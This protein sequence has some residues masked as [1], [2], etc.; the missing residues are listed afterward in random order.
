MTEQTQHYDDM[1]AGLLEEV[2]GEGYMSPGGP[3]EVARVLAGLDL[4]GLRVLD[5]GC[6]TGAI[7]LSLVQDHGAAYAVGIDVE[8]HVCDEARTRAANAGASDKVE[9]VLVDPGPLPFDEGH[10]DLVFSKDSIIHIADKEALAADIFRVLRPGGVFAASD[11]LTNHDGEMSPAMKRYVDLEGL[12]FAMASPERYAAAMTAAGFKDI[13]TNSR[14]AW[15]LSQAGDELAFLSGS[16]RPRLDS[17][18][19][20]QLVSDNIEVW[21]AMIAVLETGELAPHHLRG[22]KPD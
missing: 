19:G 21:H 11:W 4:T 5:I 20:A 2:W 7:A 15:Y 9:I 3:D 1:F 17:Q 14:N 10:F 22:H 16:E 12:G 8:A 18:Y 6:G 13:Q